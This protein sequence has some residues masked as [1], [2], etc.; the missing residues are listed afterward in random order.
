MVILALA[1]PGGWGL[2]QGNSVDFLAATAKSVNISVQSQSFGSSEAIA[3]TV[4]T[5]QLK[6]IGGQESFLTEIPEGTVYDCDDHRA[7]KFY[8]DGYKLIFN[9]WEHDS[10]ECKTYYYYCIKNNGKSPAI[11]HYLFGSSACYKTC[12]DELPSNYFGEWEINNGNVS[13]DAGGLTPIEM[14][15]D[16][17][18][19]YCGVKFDRS[20]NGYSSE[21]AYISVDGLQSL[22]S[23]K[24]VY[25][26]GRDKIYFYGIPGPE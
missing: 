12:I 9:G 11:S 18:T 10:I 24:A 8:E 19:N 7:K 13:R 1:L 20:V 3:S 21:Q 4:P 2:A 17:T 22:G 14:G 16:P 15:H 23:I 26:A 6:E 5:S 25:K